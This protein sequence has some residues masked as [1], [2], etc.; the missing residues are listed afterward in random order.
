MG[1]SLGSYG[2]LTLIG[3]VLFAA[4][5]FILALSLIRII[6]RIRYRD[7]GDPLHP[8]PKGVSI[9]AVILAFILIAASQAFF[10]L[11]SQLL[12]FRP[13]VEG[14]YIARV[15]VERQADP[16]RTLGVSYFPMSG[17]SVGVPSLFQLSGDSWNF[18]GEIL[19]FK[20]A[21]KYLNLPNRVFKTTEFHSRYAAGAPTNVSGAL[22]ATNQ[23]EGGA[24][25]VFN[26]F[27]N[28]RYFNW[29]AETDTFGIDFVKTESSNDFA[30]RLRPDGSVRLVGEDSTGVEAAASVK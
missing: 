18:K 2:R 10:W 15:R 19:R 5:I 9:L 29:F 28:G 11:S 14:G 16:L 12:F 22:F 17:D 24:S 25:A 13:V 30:I 1:S 6:R 20:F 27:R 26:L 21:P 23:I 3:A 8:P 7:T 4:G